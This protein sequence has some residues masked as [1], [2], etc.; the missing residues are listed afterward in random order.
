MDFTKAKDKKIIHLRVTTGE[1][2]GLFYQ[3]FLGTLNQDLI[4]AHG[5]DIRLQYSFRK[6]FLR[7]ILKIHE[8]YSARSP[9]ST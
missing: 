6:P 9:V 2:V 4:S 1:L 7:I 8:I 3:G 5:T